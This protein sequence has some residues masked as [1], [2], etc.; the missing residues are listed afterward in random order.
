MSRI[1]GPADAYDGRC[2]EGIDGPPGPLERL[3]T[4]AGPDHRT[5]AAT[6]LARAR[7]GAV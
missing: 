6:A 7:P 4:T 1:H 3:G 5:P 2:G